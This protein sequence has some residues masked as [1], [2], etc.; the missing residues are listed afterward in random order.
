M[1]PMAIIHNGTFSQ[2]G[3]R[4]E[5]GAPA[6]CG[7]K[8]VSS[9]PISSPAKAT[10]EANDCATL[11]ASGTKNALPISVSAPSSA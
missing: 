8:G 10:L 4:R 7:V 6:I 9:S 1:M 2:R 11:M 3:D 5:M